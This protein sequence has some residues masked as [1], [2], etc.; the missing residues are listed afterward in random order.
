MFRICPECLIWSISWLNGHLKGDRSQ[1][2]SWRGLG[3]K[4]WII[5]VTWDKFKTLCS[6]M[7]WWPFWCMLVH[8]GAFWCTSCATP[9][10]H[11]D[12]HWLIYSSKCPFTPEIV[13]ISHSG[14]IWNNLLCHAMD[15]ILVHYGALWCILVNLMCNPMTPWWLAPTPTPFQVSIYSRNGLH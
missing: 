12:L 13:H 2:K 11:N 1:N 8:F 3:V 14:Q 5:L 4:K 9:W 15:T 6:V 7:L 10:P